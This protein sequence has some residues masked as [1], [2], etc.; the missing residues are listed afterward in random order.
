[1]RLPV[2]AT[3]PFLA[4]TPE[5][6]PSLTGKTVA[7]ALY[8][9]GCAQN[10]IYTDAA[11]ATVS[12]LRK[13]GVDVFIPR[14]QV[15]CGTPVFNSGDVKGARALAE[16]NL[17]IFVGDAKG[18]LRLQRTSRS[19]DVPE[20]DF[21]VTSCGSCGLT[22][23]E[24]W[25]R[26]LGLDGAESVSGKV[27]DIS[28]LLVDR[29]GMSIP[30][31][32]D[33]RPFGRVT[34]HDSCHLNRGMGVSTQP[35]KLLSA[36]PGVELVEMADAARCCGGG[37]AFCLYHPEES[38]RVAEVKMAAVAESGAQAAVTGCPSCLMQLE[39]SLF[40]RRMPQI[41]LHVAQALDAVMG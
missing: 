8:F 34:Y 38:Q 25:K 36:A 17:R 35:R 29:L 15:C 12:V 7:R 14:E 21:I 32:E 2:P 6:L 37:G 19:I 41:A 26:T 9:V 20:V 1:M 23:R 31:A 28:E 33:A 39:D 13:V 3:R 11:R 18:R 4:D 40:R 27:V 16:R 5:F 10:Y 24:E 30:W 22:L